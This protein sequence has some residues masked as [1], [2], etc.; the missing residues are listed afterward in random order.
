LLLSPLS[1]DVL[2]E[3]KN[4]LAF[5]AGVDSSALFF[6]LMH[7]KVEFDIALVNYHT[8]E[9]SSK[10]AKRARHLAQKFQKKA[11]IKEVLLKNSNFEHQA[12]RV[13]Y[14]FFEEII[15]KYRYDNLVTAHHL[16][17]KLEWFMMQLTK[18]AGL[19]EMLGFDEIEHRERYTLVR[20]LIECD[21]KSLKEYLKKNDIE[22]F[23]DDS[24]FDTKYR[25]NYFRKEFCDKLTKEFKDGIKKSFRYLQKDKSSLFAIKLLKKEKE[26]HILK[27]MKDETYDIRQIDK[28]LK[29]MGYILSAAQKEEI[30]R[31]KDIV[32]SNKY[33]IAV[34][35]EKIYIA[36]FVKKAMPKDF[37]ERCRKEAIPPKIRPYL[38]QIDYDFT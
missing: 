35:D 20:P 36:P 2:K 22:Y 26:F 14:D 8:R 5:S 4:L 17:D 25:R 29:K 15:K 30:I 18:G 33:C 23:T 10:E 11:Y 13:R 1:L 12:R 28:I 38:Y 16:N 21:K 32:I 37:K 31:Q 19:V 7:E 27:R 3:K 24:N 6:I 34:E 9:S